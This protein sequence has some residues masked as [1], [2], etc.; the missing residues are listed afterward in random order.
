MMAWGVVKRG[1]VVERMKKS[2]EG[3]VESLRVRKGDRGSGEKENMV[4]V[5]KGGDERLG[6]GVG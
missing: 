6:R 4:G 3:G 5:R 2:G 1:R